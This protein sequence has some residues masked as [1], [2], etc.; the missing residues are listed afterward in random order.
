MHPATAAA[1]DR[2]Y[3]RVFGVDEEDLW[4]DLTVRTHRRL[5]DYPGWYVAWRGEGV[6]VSSP[7]DAPAVDAGMLAGCEIPELQD[8]AFWRRFADERGLRL[9]GPATHTYLDAD[10]LARGGRVGDGPADGDGAGDGDGDGVVALDA[11]QREQLRTTVPAAD[12]EEAGWADRPAL[13][14][15]L[16][17]EGRVV[18]AANLRPVDGAPLDVGV[19]VAPAHRGRGLAERVG[20]HAASWAVRHHGHARWSSRDDNA[21]SLATARRIGFETWC[22]QVAVR[23]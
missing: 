4:C 22:A 20:R 15:G 3:A 1:V 10:P 2:S 5:G 21:A 14:W 13:A 12:W 16:V 23:P 11:A 6:H 9:V 7:V 18:A 19:L 17:V 8:V